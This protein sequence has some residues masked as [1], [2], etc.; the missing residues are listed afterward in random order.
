TAANT[1]RLIEAI[2]DDVEPPLDGA[3]R[4]WLEAS[5]EVYASFESAVRFRANSERYGEVLFAGE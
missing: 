1:R 2:R 4:D 3:M 5:V